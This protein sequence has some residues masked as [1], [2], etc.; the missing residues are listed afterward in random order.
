MKSYRKELWFNIPTRRSFI[1]IT[2]EVHTC[3]AESG[4]TEGPRAGE[5][6]AHHCVSL[7]QRR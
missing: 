5:R 1:N 6:D 7:H 3:L 2:P 4:I